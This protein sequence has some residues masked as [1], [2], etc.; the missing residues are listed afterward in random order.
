MGKEEKT[1][2]P[3]GLM[4]FVIKVL[5]LVI[6]LLMMGM[7]PTTAQEY[8]L[9]WTPVSIQKTIACGDC[10][11]LSFTFQ[12][13]Q[14]LKD[15]DL[16]VSESPHIMTLSKDHFDIVKANTPYEI[17]LYIHVPYETQGG[18]MN[19][20]ISLRHGFIK[21]PQVLNVKLNIV[22]TGTPIVAMEGVEW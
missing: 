15:V 19:G 4:V 2:K 11:S 14:E 6:C 9:V 5:L 17:E 12:S 1:M 21:A 3:K 10:E 7:S 20:A 8:P 16:L 22:D 18:T 13:K